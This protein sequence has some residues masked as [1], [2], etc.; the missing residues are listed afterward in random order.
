MAC[1]SDNGIV[2]STNPDTSITTV[3][4]LG[5]SKNESG[6]SVVK[7]TDGGYAILGFSQSADGDITDKLNESYDF[8]VLKYSATHSL[9]WSK[10]YGGSGDDRGEKIIQTQDGGFVILGYSDSADGDL[11]DNAGAQDYWLAKLDSN[12]NLLWQKSFGY[13]GADRGKSVLETTDGGYFLTGILDVTASGGAGNTR[14]A[15]SR[16]A[17]GDY[18][19]LKLDS[20]GTIDWSKYYGGS[21][22][23]TPFDAIETADSGYII[24]GSS[25]SDDVDIANNIGDYDFW[26]VKISNSGAI[27]WEKNFGGTQIDEARGIINSADGN[28]LIIGDTRSNDI[29]VSNNLGAADL[30]LIKISSEGNLLWEKTYGGS[31]FDV[32]RSISKGNKNTFILSGSSRS[33]NGNLNSNKGQNDAWFLKI[34]ANGTVIKQKSVGGSAIDYC[35]NAIELNDDTI[36]AVGESS[37]SDGDILENKGFSDLLI[38]KTK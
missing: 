17:G 20:Q 10:T 36:I 1:S 22:T 30:W 23:D 18:W 2:D 21:F 27:I 16:H 8:W 31:N 14:D 5:G 26:V 15:S 32:G 33:A 37:S 9:Q 13:L 4:T 6:Q 11:T 24:V 25:D 28:F 29:Q 34:D 19:A 38:I 3:L 12:G 7:T 35:Y